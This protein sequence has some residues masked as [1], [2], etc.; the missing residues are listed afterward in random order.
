VVGVV[1]FGGGLGMLLGAWFRLATLANVLNLGGLLVL[2]ALAGGI[3][4]PLPGGDPLPGFREAFLILAG[5]ASLALSGPGRLSLADRL[6]GSRH[7]PD[8]AAKGLRPGQ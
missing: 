7:T 2:G 6:R 4:A 1:E 5:A 3:P 8:V